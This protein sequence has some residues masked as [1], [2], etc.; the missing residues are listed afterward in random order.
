MKNKKTKII[1]LSSFNPSKSNLHPEKGSDMY[2]IASWAGSFARRL[3]TRYPA[4]DI[5]VWRP[6]FEFEK[7]SQK[8]VY[9]N[10][11]GVIFP[12]KF[13]LIKNVLT[14]QMLKKLLQYQKQYRLVIHLNTIYNLQFNLFAPRILKET[15]II[16]SHHGGKPPK[17]NRIKNTIKN[18][19]LTISYKNIDGVTYLRKEIK[20]WI[21]LN[22]NSP[23]LQFLPVG[24][25]FNLMYPLN[26]IK[27]RKILG[28]KQNLIYGIY[29]GRF[30][31]L[32]SVDIILDVY[33]RLKDKYKFS[34][35]F[36]GGTKKDELYDQIKDSGCPFWELQKWE[37]IKYFLSAADFYIHPV[38]NDDFGGFDTTLI[39]AMACNI[40]VISPQLEELEFNYSE[41]GIYLENKN[42]IDEKVE[43]MIKN[44]DRY[45]NCRKI[46]SQ[47]LDGNTVIIDE[48]RHLLMDN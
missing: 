25:N 1:E 47:F 40:P 24:A 15:R 3:K 43:M 21:K 7:I 18:K 36:L 39:E 37:K 10:I 38:F 23:F 27:C 6:E 5:E 16:L 8:T 46:A 13:P 22:T 2:Y 20:D 42:K 28:L 14:F 30:Y 17:K 44:Y 26:K 34:V 19:M 31:K 4:L 12:Y 32:K 45:V 11:Q 33:K 9:N 41:L 35:I 29:I 48:L